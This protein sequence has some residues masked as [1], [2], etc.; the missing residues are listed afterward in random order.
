MTWEKEKRSSKRYQYWTN[1]TLKLRVR[2]E[3]MAEGAR[4]ILEPTWSKGMNTEVYEK[5]YYQSKTRA[6]N[7]AKKLME[8]LERFE[9]SM[10][11]V[12]S[13]LSWDDRKRYRDVLRRAHKRILRDL[14]QRPKS[15][16]EELLKR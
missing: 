9:S 4:T 13:D 2:V 12:A 1:N 14:G 15:I 6:K 8:K 7:E 5:N 11:R 3:G 10:K 16:T